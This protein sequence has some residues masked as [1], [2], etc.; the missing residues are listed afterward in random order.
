MVLLD[1]VCQIA[2]EKI[3]ERGAGMPGPYTAPA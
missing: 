2:V 1:A 3:I